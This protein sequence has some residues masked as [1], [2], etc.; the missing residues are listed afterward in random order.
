MDRTKASV[1]VKYCQIIL[2]NV[3][4][5]EMSASVKP[6]RPRGP[7]AGSARVRPGSAGTAEGAVGRAAR[8]AARGISWEGSEVE[9]ILPIDC[10]FMIIM[11]NDL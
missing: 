4:N 5:L 10:R 9:Q 7:A 2:I 8:P 11:G 6:E 1:I 3:T